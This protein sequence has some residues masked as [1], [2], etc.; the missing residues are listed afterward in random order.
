MECNSIT[1]AKRHS[2]K[3]CSFCKSKLKL[4]EGVM[5]YDRNWYHNEC[6]EYFEKKLE[7]ATK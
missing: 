3:I 5:V 6:W 1:I 2:E 4:E 7:V